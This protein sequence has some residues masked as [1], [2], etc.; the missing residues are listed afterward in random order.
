MPCSV[1]HHSL[2]FPLLVRS[3]L[4]RSTGMSDPSTQEEVAARPPPR[5]ATTTSQR[6]LESDELYA[7]QLAEHYGGA[8]QS[9]RH[10]QS[11]GD[12]EP[13]LPRT[14]RETGLK[15]NELQDDEEHSFFDGKK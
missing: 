1:L 5:T 8:T 11:G 15:P 6:Q 3:W 14:R 2:L 9:R 10:P 12:H 13:D 7:R 4:I